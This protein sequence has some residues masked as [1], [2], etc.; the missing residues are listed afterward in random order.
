MFHSARRVWLAGFILLAGGAVHADAADLPK[1]AQTPKGPAL[2]DAKGM[3]L[4]TFDK[5]S[6]G[7]SACYGKCAENWPPLMADPTASAPAGYSLITR[8]DGGKQWAYQGKPLYRW[9]KDAKPG[10]ETGD[11]VNGSWHVARP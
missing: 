11:G 5:D 4:Y 10:D 6:G 9:A 3:A 8:D 2:T 1:V 7:K